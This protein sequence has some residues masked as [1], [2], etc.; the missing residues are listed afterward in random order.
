[1]NS[2]KLKI[3]AVQMNSGPDPVKNLELVR[4]YINKAASSGAGLAVFPETCLYRGPAAGFAAV[5]EFSY[6]MALPRIKRLAARLG[7]DVLLGSVHEPSA[8]KGKFYNTALLITHTGKTGGKYRKIHLFDAAVKGKFSVKESDHYVPGRSTSIS[9]IRGFTA[10]IAVCYDLRFPGMFAS[11]IK[12][13]SEI[14][15]LF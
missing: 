4:K 14:P 11:L 6:K 1:M 10:G 8:L 15:H 5:S 2:R 12:K 13:R 3:A 9:V 7:I